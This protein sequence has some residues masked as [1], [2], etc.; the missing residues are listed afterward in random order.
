M[1]WTRDKFGTGVGHYIICALGHCHPRWTFMYISSEGLLISIL[2]YDTFL[3]LV[4][5]G[6][7]ALSADEFI[8]SV[9]QLNVG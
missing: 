4:I 1:T 3:I 8:S 7:P 6:P 5:S 9:Q 2:G